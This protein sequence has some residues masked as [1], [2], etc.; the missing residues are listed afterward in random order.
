MKV[1]FKPTLAT[2]TIKVIKNRRDRYLIL[3]ARATCPNIISIY[4]ALLNHIRLELESRG[5]K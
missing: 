1:S 3:K 2:A 4:D 5:I